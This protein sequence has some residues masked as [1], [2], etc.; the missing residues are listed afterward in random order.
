MSNRRYDMI[1]ISV[2]QFEHALV[3]HSVRQLRESAQ[4]TKHQSGF[5]CFKLAAADVAG[6]DSL[7]CCRA[8][9]GIEERQLDSPESAQFASIAQRRDDTV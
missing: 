6:Q 1:E 4:I 7:C 8:Y 2:E 9:I 3:G 5:E